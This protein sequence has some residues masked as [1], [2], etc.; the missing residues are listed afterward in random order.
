MQLRYICSVENINKIRTVIL[1]KEYFKEFF[2]EQREKV[3]DKITW[4]LV[5]DKK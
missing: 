4:T 5:H 3:Q 2:A 1:Y